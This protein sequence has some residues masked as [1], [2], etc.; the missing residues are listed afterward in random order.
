MKVESRTW[1]GEANWDSK[2]IP[3]IGGKWE[4]WALEDKEIGNE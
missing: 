2:T 1:G 3:F 4:F